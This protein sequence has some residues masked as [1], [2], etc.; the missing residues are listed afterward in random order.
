M[1]RYLRVYMCVYVCVYMCVYVCV[2]VCMCVRS[3]RAAGTVSAPVACSHC[4]RTFRRLQHM[5]RHKCSEPEDYGD[6]STQSVVR[7]RDITFW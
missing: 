4:Q 3:H 6:L 5:A 1:N 2:C 7:Q